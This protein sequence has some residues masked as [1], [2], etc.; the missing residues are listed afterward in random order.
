MA[1]TAVYDLEAF[2]LDAVNAFINRY[3]DE[4]VYCA[5]PDGFQ[6]EEH[7]L[8]LLRALYGLRRSPLLRL[9]EFSAALK[10]LGFIEVP[11]EPCLFINKDG[12]IIIFYVDDIV[13]LCRPEAISKL[14]KLRIALMQRYEMRD[15]DELSWFLGIRIIRN[16]LQRKL[17]LCQDSYIKKIAASFRLTD[18]KP[19]VTPLAVEEL[20]QNDRQATPQEIYLYQRKVGSLLYAT[21]ITR[22]DAARAASKLSEFLINPSARHQGAVDRAISYLYGTNTRAIEYSAT[23]LNQQAVTCAGDAAFVDDPATRYSTEGYLLK[24]FNGP[25]DWC[26]TKQK[27]VTTSSTEAELLALSRAAKKVIWWKR[28]FKAVQLNFDQDVALSCNNRQTIRLLTAETPQINTKL[29]HVDIHDHWLRQEVANGVLQIQWVPTAEMP[30]DGLTKALPCQKHE[31]LVKQLSLVDISLHLHHEWL[32]PGGFVS[33]GHWQTAL[34]QLE[35]PI[36]G[37]AIHPVV[38]MVSFSLSF[39]VSHA[40]AGQVLAE[41]RRDVARPRS[42]PSAVLSDPR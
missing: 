21:T 17:W 11:G 38:S 13:L 26:S 25:I 33:D 31:T 16:P 32:Q 29:K 41:S 18:R 42:I 23:D 12:I 28:F 40:P 20:V 14:R 5:F 37:L 39:E 30:A 8:L 24:L 1:I 35:I 19:P 6:Q 2:Q 10:D 15:L 36:S 3:L 4:T 22:P 34:T 9:K 27:T 7:C